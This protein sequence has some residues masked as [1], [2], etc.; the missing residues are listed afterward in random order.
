[1]PVTVIVR[2]GGAPKGVQTPAGAA[3]SNLSITLD[4]P[5]IVVGRGE[6][7]EV[8]LPD[9]S[10]SHRHATIRQRG[11]EYILVDEG[12]TNGT[13]IG[14]VKLGALAPRILKHGDL[15]RVGRVWLEIRFDN[16]VAPAQTVLATKELALALVA[17]AM[18]KEGDA[19]G[20]RITI[21]GGPDQGKELRL[22]EPGRAYVVGR[23]RDV[24]LVVEDVDASR[25]H[26]EIVRRADQVTV[27]DLGSK[28][29]ALLGGQRLEK[30]G[31][32]WKQG[33]ELRVGTNTLA[34]E[35][36]ALDALGDLERAADEKIRS[37]ESIP[38]PEAVAAKGPRAD[39]KPPPAGSAPS[40][41]PAADSRRAIGMGGA[42]I[43]EV[44]RGQAGAL[45]RRSGWNSTDFIVVLLALGVLALSVL[46]L[47]WL[48]RG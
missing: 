25:R 34:Y 1:M 21:A 27:R 17:R 29:G 42:P 3:V 4:S 9:P 6:G 28:N 24:D 32:A 2:S 44:P 18:D 23:G 43:A 35:Y 37:D 13:F 26:V 40:A 39:S 46:G 5:M 7:S 47:Y 22:D 16:Q 45:R 33:Q 38:P 10:V 12:S 20:P 30:Q 15:A 36:P 8:R 31:R 11:S 48:L 14:G 19:G 41:N